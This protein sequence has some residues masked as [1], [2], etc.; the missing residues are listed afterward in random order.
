M[1]IQTSKAPDSLFYG[2]E[3]SDKLYVLS[4]RLSNANAVEM[5]TKLQLAQSSYYRSMSEIHRG[6][7][8]S[9]DELLC[10]YFGPSGLPEN[11]LSEIVGERYQDYRDGNF[12][13]ESA[14]EYADN[15]VA[16]RETVLDT[17]LDWDH[18]P[19]GTCPEVKQAEKR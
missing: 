8:H 3:I 5:R 1:S 7:L 12:A 6:Y 17:L 19:E 15:T 18:R 11:L 16:I 10:Q 13:T 4:Q 2:P 9:L 14:N